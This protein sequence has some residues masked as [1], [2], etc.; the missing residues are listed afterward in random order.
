[1]DSTTREE[2]IKAKRHLDT[3]VVRRNFRK[4]TERYKLLE[5][6]Y[7]FH[8]HFMAEEFYLHLIQN[9]FQVSMATVYNNLVF[10]EEV[11]LVLKHQFGKGQAAR[12]ERALGRKQHCHLICLRCNQIFEFCDPRIHHIQTT[13]EEHFGATVTGHSLTLYGECNRE[14]CRNSYPVIDA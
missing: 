14:E 4:S 5:E 2:F 6:L 10:F 13:V 1:M 7:K 3:E 9:N 11:G 12:Y 8:D